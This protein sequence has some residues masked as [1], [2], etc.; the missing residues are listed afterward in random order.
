M[1]YAVILFFYAL[2]AMLLYCRYRRDMA[3]ILISKTLASLGFLAAGLLALQ[4]NPGAA[5]YALWIVAGLG[6]SVAGDVFLV[7]GERHGA[8][9]WGLFFFLLAHIA[10]GVVFTGLSGL[11]VWDAVFFLLLTGAGVTVRRFARIDLGRM[12]FPVALYLLAISYMTAQAFSIC[13]AEGPTTLA[14]MA[15]LGAL[16]FFVSDAFLA[17]NTFKRSFNAYRALNLITYY[18]GQ[19]LLA[20]SILFYG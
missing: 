3:W 6:L 20:L 16:L 13:L 14:V 8:F 7:Y 2:L 1:W 15:G 11:Q 5:G 19:L 9:M 17:W 10:Y 12:T 18:T 4:Q